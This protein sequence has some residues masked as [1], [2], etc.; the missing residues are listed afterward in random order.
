MDLSD[1]I[2]VYKN[3]KTI[4]KKKNFSNLCT[5]IITSKKRFCGNYCHQKNQLF[6]RRCWRHKKLTSKILPPIVIIMIVSDKIYNKHIWF[7]FLISCDKHN[8][9]LELVIYN[10]YMYK[11]TVRN[12]HNFISRFR[13]SSKIFLKKYHIFS[14]TNNHASITYVNVY[15]DMLKYVT[16]IPNVSKCF[17]ITESTI[18]IRSPI[19]LYKSTISFSKCVLDIS[20]NV[21][22]SNKIPH[23]LP[24]RGRRRPFELVNNRAQCMYTIDFLKTALPTLSLYSKYFGI[25]DKEKEG[26]MIMNYNL[27]KEWEEVTGAMLDEFWLLNSFV[28]HLYFNDELYPMKYIK[29]NVESNLPEVDRLVVADFPEWRNDTRRSFIFNSFD[30]TNYIKHFDSYSKKYYSGLINNNSEGK[31]NHFISKSLNEI[32]QYLRTKKSN[33]LFFRSVKIRE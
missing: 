19:T 1:D 23:S 32:I 21:K 24:L 28:L 20:Y 17:V 29:S 7:D 6:N 30:S 10:Q 14:L 3:L 22:F 12:N 2:D 26:Y 8:V 31:S 15:Y 27:L 5:K 18:P 4:N 9:P 11:G 25:E 33:V 16:E 13:P